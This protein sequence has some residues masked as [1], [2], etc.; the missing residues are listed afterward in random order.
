MAVM[1]LFVA[2]CEQGPTTTGGVGPYVGGNNALQVAFE[3]GMPPSEFGEDDVVDVKV[4]VVNL[5]EYEVPENTV[6]IKLF[7]VA[8]SEFSSL[9]FNFKP[10]SSSLYP[11]EKGIFEIG[12]EAIVDMGQID[13]SGVINQQYYDTT[14]FAKACYPYQTKSDIEACITSKRIEDSDSEEVCSYTSSGL[15]SGTVSGG[16]VQITSFTEELRGLSQVSFKIGFENKGTG[17]VYNDAVSCEE[18]DDLSA[19]HE[20]NKVHIKLNNADAEAISCNFPSGSGIEGDL[21]LA[22]GQE[23][24]LVCIM[25]VDQTAQYTQSLDITVDYKYTETTKRDLRILSNQ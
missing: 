21:T 4:K 13:Y 7:G 15:G 1:V 18:I 5:G 12:G 17:N 3:E 20:R 25:D 14:L 22:E 23:K 19:Q 10:V 8:P 6:K 24:I 2:A 11:V 16:P 9:D